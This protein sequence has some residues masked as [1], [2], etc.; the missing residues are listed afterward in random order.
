MGGIKRVAQLLVL[1]DVEVEVTSHC[2]CNGLTWGAD[3]SGGRCGCPRSWLAALRK[4][5]HISVCWASRTSTAAGGALAGVI[6]DVLTAALNDG[7]LRMATM[8][9]DGIFDNCYTARSP[10][11]THTAGSARSIHYIYINSINGTSR[12]NAFP[13]ATGSDDNSTR[14]HA[15]LPNRIGGRAARECRVLNSQRGT[16]LYM[17]RECTANVRSPPTLL[18]PPSHLFVSWSTRRHGPHD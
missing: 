15:P 1:S 14:M 2:M 4:R 13:L 10:G 11:S 9:A 12:L 5:R 3:W 16:P 6:L 7:L 18:G 8:A 17:Q